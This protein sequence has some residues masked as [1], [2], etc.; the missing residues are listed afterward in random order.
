MSTTPVVSSLT[1]PTLEALSSDVLRPPQ[2]EILRKRP[3]HFEDSQVVLQV[4]RNTYRIHRYFLVRESLFFRDLFSLPQ[5]G[6]AKFVEGSD[7]EHPITLPDTTASEFEGLL[8]FLYFGMHDDNSPTLND[9]MAILSIST[10][11]IF[12]KVRE[13]AIKEIATHLDQMDPFELI[14]L[15]IKHD[16]HQWLKPACV[17]IVTRTDLISHAEALKVPS[18]IAVML[19]RSREQYLK[20]RSDPSS[21]IDSEV[22]LMDLASRESQRETVGI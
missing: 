3:F 14:E 4:E 19:M 7:D 2:V 11:F 13:R 18:P 6:D 15:T 5:S 16:V 17:K 10:R 9:W 1:V 8:R 12:D 21:I 22:R 20:N